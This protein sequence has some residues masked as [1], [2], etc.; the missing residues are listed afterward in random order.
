[1]F[2]KTAKA[3]FIQQVA[4][5]LFFTPL[6]SY[7]STEWSAPLL[8][9]HPL[10]GKIYSVDDQAFIT[11]KALLANLRRAHYVLIGEKHDNED[12]HRLELQLLE[13]LLNKP[14]THVVFEMLT[15][16][17]QNNIALLTSDD[18]K[19]QIRTKLAWNDKGWPW[20]DYAPLIQ[21]SLKKGASISA[22]NI[23]RAT[24]NQIYRDLCTT[25]PHTG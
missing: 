22:G 8:Q 2:K 13:S 9:N 1:M 23:H 21:N 3:L 20:K 12:H 19:D 14:H 11:E 10:V 16:K 25:T 4:F 6:F 17:Q 15:D 18:S 5:F 7:A 24:I